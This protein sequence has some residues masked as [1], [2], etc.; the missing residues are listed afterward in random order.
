S[1]CTASAG[2]ASTRAGSAANM[3]TLLHA[4][5]RALYDAKRE[6]HNRLSVAPPID[7]RALAT[8]Q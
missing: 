2:I 5:D 1:L 3:E 8:P 6:G 7:L 4:A